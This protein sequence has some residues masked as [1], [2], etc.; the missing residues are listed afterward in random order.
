MAGY[1]M[2]QGKSNTN[3]SDYFLGG[4][5]LPWIVA[6]FSIVA[7]ETSV[8][9]FVSIPGVAYRGDWTFLQL[10]LGYI[11]GR[12]L[13]SVFL[14]PMYFANGVTS[15]Y[16]IIGNKYGHTMQR[17]ASTIF[18]ITRILADGVRF[19]A[20]AV[21]VQVVT[22]WSLPM[23]VLVIGIVT[24]IYTLYGGI[25]TI[26]WLDSI[27][28]ILYLVGGFISILFIL[29]HLD[30]GMFEIV[31]SLLESN[32]LNIVN[33][34]WNLF[35]E[36]WAFGS[37]V[38]GGILLSFASHGV[39]YMMV[40]RVLGCRDIKSAKKAMVGSGIF[41]FIQFAVFLTVGSL[42]YLYFDGVTL[43]KDREFSTFIVE[44]LPIGLKG[45]LLAGVLSAAMSTLSS[46]INSLASSTVTDWFKQTVPL[47]KSRIISLFWA[48]V[49]VGIALVF[50]END[51]AIVIVGLKIA[52]FTYGGLLGLFLLTKMDRHFSVISLVAGLISS[53]GI[54]FVAQ[55]YGLA[56]TWFIAVSVLINITV[57]WVVD[58]IVNK[59]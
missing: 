36:S 47:S 52:S 56:W 16:E 34:S 22:G 17:V 26:V 35:S 39:D 20:T 43:V 9:T 31:P 8:L 48:I 4:R 1:G 15:I 45:L 29:N 51:S 19:L 21:I 11:I 14:L 38:I 50:D 18:L 58:L 57:V 5:N 41:V 25:K 53:L 24:I 12:I 54:V 3:N 7:T 23:S 44:S 27:Q 46:S 59:R 42:M 32:K 30:M 55:F 2:W 28:F 33:P 37:A 6:M 40:Q 13:V 49:L 10:A